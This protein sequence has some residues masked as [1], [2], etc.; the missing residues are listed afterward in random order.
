M[1]NEHRGENDDEMW[2]I[3]D[4]NRIPVGRTHRR[5]DPLAAGELH[6]VVHVCIFNSKSLL[7]V[8]KRQPWKKEFPGLWDLS[9]AGSVISGETSRQAAVREAKEELG[10]DLDLRNTRPKF[11]VNFE[12]GF[13]DYYVVKKNIDISRLTLQKDEVSEV[14]WASKYELLHLTASKEMIPYYFLDLL[15]EVINATHAYRVPFGAI[16]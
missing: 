3:L 1:G 6:Q 7:L 13:D 5:G 14:K 11:T 16:R 2:D 8:Q 12:H 15:F 10:L 4:E 9:V